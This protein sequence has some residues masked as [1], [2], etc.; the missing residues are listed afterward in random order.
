[1]MCVNRQNVV[2]DDKK[3]SHRAKRVGDGREC[4]MG[5]H[6][7]AGEVIHGLSNEE[8]QRTFGRVGS[9]QTKVNL[10]CTGLHISNVQPSG[11]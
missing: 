10:G 11:V 2:D 6:R 3:R 7:S 1:M 9:G 4:C 8:I 5:N